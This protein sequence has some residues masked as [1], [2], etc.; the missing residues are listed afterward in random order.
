MRVDLSAT[1][2]REGDVGRRMEQAS[3]DRPRLY[4]DKCFASA[5]DIEPPECSYGAAGGERTVALIGDSHAAQWFPAV[6]K[7]ALAHGLKLVVFV[8]AGCPLATVEPFYDKL[9]RPYVECTQWREKVFERLARER[10]I[11]VIGANSSFY[12]AFVGRDIAA[13]AQW[14]QGLE[15]SLDRLGRISAHVAV[16]RDTPRPDF[17]VPACL[18]SAHKRGGKSAPACTFPLAESVRPDAVDI[19][20]A[21]A[22][23]PNVAFIDLTDA[24]CTGGTCRAEGDGVVLYHDSQHLTATFARSLTDAL[25]RQLPDAARADLGK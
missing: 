15:A 18:A 25:W 8:K 11:L 3:R 9:N 23:R 7:L 4:E 13:Q 22:R 21:A 14:R 5:L 6:E 16:I 12:D 24:I 17:H 20:R 19:E 1:G 2:G 10:P